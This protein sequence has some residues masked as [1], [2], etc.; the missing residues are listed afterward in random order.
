MNRSPWSWIPTLFAAEEIPASIVTYV[1]L[2]MFLQLDT[3]PAVATCYCGLL[4][5]PW[6]LKSF[7][8]ARVRLL[9][10]FRHQIQ[11]LELAIVATLMVMAFVFLRYTHRSLMLFG[12]LF[13]LS[14]LTAWHE[15]AARM[16]YERMLFPRQQRYYNGLK[17]FFSQAAVVLTYGV[18]IMFVGAL[19]VFYRRIPRSW[20]EGCYL[21][22]GIFLLFLCYHLWAL[23]RPP[24]GDRKRKG[25]TL[26][27]VRE[28]M[29]IIDRIRQKPHWLL[30]VMG[31]ALLLLP[32][33]LMFYSRVLFFLASRTDGGLGCTLIDVGFAQGTVGVIAFSIGVMLGRQLL[34]WVDVQR[35]FWWM[36]VSLGL[37]P[38][39]YLMMTFEPPSSLMVLCV[40][41]FQAQFF[42][43]FGLSLCTFF[44][45]YISGER[46]RNTINY[47]YVP[48]VA[49][50]M[51]VPL[52]LSGWLVDQLG[53]RTFFL[54]DVVSAPLAW[55]FIYLSRVR[56]KLQ[57]RTP[58][59]K[60]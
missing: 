37:S 5:L 52:S 7:F 10:H 36:A 39:L 54:I 25:S 30:A 38:I 35:L 42:F 60:S 11:C 50:V 17:I 15:L 13:L 57:I 31:M 8:R 59:E 32:Q 9:G 29:L 58:N 44:V 56:H 33:S 41:T 24:V 12:G 22:A 2:L 40:A 55:T 19:Q 16:Y 53:F 28:E 18:L 49:T 47:L 26:G 6:V 21:A 46:Y 51:L 20:S 45:R 48:L 34:H 23:S 14:F 43:G 27:A 3:T 1:A 4:F